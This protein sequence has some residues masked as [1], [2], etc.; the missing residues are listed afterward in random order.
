[1]TDT[2]DR[3]GLD[4]KCR[5]YENLPALIA[6]WDGQFWQQSQWFFGVESVLLGAVGVALKDTFL[7]GAAPSRPAFLLL[8]SFCVFNFWICYVW[9]RTNRSNREYLDPLLR[10]ARAIEAAILE[11]NDTG[12]FSAQQGSLTLPEHERHSAHRW[13]IHL[14]SGFALAWAAAL[15]A[16]ALYGHRFCLALSTLTLSLVAL[17]LLEHFVP[18]RQR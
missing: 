15:L 10:R 11:N 6:H 14:P 8:V 2:S 18:K 12:T 13:V 7:S 4:F 3:P 16:A 5:E 9:F 17:L 1:M